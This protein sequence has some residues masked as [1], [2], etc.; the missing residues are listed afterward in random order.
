MVP[1]RASPDN[2]DCTLN[3]RQDRSGPNVCGRRFGRSASSQA[4]ANWATVMSVAAA[5]AVLIEHVDDLY[6]QV[7][8]AVLKSSAVSRNVT[9][10]SWAASI[11]VIASASLLASP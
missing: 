1:P 5:D 7:A 10:A 2:R 8:Q 4:R 3:F 11:V 6:A 9:P